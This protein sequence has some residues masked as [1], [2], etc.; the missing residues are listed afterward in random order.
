ML[1]IQLIRHIIFDLIDALRILQG[2][3]LLEPWKY[4]LRLFWSSVA[5]LGLLQNLTV[6]PHTCGKIPG[7]VMTW[8]KQ[9]EIF[10][11]S[12]GSWNWQETPTA[13]ACCLPRSCP[14]KVRLTCPCWS[15]G[16][17]RARLGE[18]GWIKWYQWLHV[19]SFILFPVN[20]WRCP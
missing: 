10:G 3:L 18:I 13:A 2:D 6:C 11:C 15:C 4:Q 16:W 9:I 1:I 20:K 8:W 5:V 19:V 7:L 14:A 12:F 17:T